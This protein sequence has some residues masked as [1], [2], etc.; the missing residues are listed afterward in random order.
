MYFVKHIYWTQGEKLQLSS[1]SIWY[2]S[3][4]TF[5]FCTNYDKVQI[6]KIV[7]NNSPTKKLYTT[8]F[9]LI[10]DFRNIILNVK[11]WDWPKIYDMNTKYWYRKDTFEVDETV[12]SKDEFELG[13]LFTIGWGIIGCLLGMSSF[14]WCCWSFIFLCVFMRNWRRDLIALLESF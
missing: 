6:Y 2:I 7:T 5:F 10:N 12:D 8:I 3:T 13:W 9:S 1:L 11:N 14:W 4:T